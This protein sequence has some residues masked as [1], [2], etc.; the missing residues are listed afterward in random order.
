MSEDNQSF[1]FRQP[2]LEVH[3]GGRIDPGDVD[4]RDEELEALSIR[5]Q[6]DVRTIDQLYEPLKKLDKTIIKLRNG[7]NIMELL[8][9]SGA[10]GKI[11]E[12]FDQ[13]IRAYINRVQ[14]GDPNGAYQAGA[15]DDIEALKFIN[16]A[17]FSKHMEDFKKDY[18]SEAWTNTTV[19]DAIFDGLAQAAAALRII[20][21][22]YVGETP[23]NYLSR[24]KGYI[25]SACIEI[26]KK[27]Y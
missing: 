18:P 23:E 20:C 26:S 1:G 13:T 12:V 27:T 2:S 8:A 4:D 19:A 6:E 5:M 11:S 17:M 3:Q 15:Y 7:I 14:H 25:P 10:S 24:L 9:Q 22:M 21:P 16:E